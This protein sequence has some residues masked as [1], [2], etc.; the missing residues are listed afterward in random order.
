MLPI[1]GEADDILAQSKGFA[2]DDEWRYYFEAPTPIEAC[3]R[4]VE[5]LT[6]NGYKLNEI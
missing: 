2:S 4:I 5:Q 3:V 1:F 6:D